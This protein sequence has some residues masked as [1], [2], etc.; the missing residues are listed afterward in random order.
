MELENADKVLLPG[1]VL[2]GPP[3]GR[4]GFPGFSETPRFRPNK[5]EYDRPPRD[6]EQFDHYWLVSQRLKDVLE[7]V[8]PEAVMF[9]D[10]IVCHIS[11]KPVEPR[12]YLCDIVREI[13]ALDEEAS[14]V[15]IEY[16]QGVKL[17]DLSRKS[18][19]IFNE[20]IVGEAHIFRQKHMGGVIGDASLRSACVA[21]GIKDQNLFSDV[22]AF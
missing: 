19:L 2:L 17:Y 14:T 4:H 16:E 12:H 3:L 7:A 9:A 11:G 15:R 10:C 22:R 13:D 5:Q 20:S 21:A 6:L 1:R 18:K 8:D